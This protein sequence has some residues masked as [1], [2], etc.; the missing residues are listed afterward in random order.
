MLLRLRFRLEEL[1]VVGK[2]VVGGEEEE[3]EEEGRGNEEYPTPVQSTSSRTH[4]VSWS[5]SLSSR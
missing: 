1:E 2:D 4:L 5:C 3:E